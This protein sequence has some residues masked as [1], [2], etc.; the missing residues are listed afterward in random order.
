MKRLLFPFVTADTALFSIDEDELKVLLVRRAS[1]PA[2]GEWALPGGAL[3]PAVDGSLEDTARRVLRD[4]ISVD[5]PHLEQVGSFSGPERDARGWSISQLFYALLPR[6]KIDALVK[7]K[8]EA[9]EWSSVSKGSSKRRLAF[10]HDKQL[11]AALKLLRGRVAQHALPLHLLPRRFTLT[12]LQRTVEAILGYEVDK[13]AFRRRIKG[14]LDLVELD[15]YVRG[16]QRPAQL[17]RAS[18]EFRFEA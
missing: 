11:A 3:K 12:E 16:S 9:V 4:K 15:E 1:P 14:S 13:S 5:I 6:D 17:F 8:V 18:D 2:K 7:T 10:D